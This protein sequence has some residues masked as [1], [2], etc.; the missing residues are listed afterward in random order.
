MKIVITFV[1]YI[2]TLSFKFIEIKQKNRKILIKPLPKNLTYSLLM[3]LV[4]IVLC[5][6]IEIVLTHTMKL[7]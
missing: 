3:V 2:Y 4:T 1:S 7:Y 5:R 6:L